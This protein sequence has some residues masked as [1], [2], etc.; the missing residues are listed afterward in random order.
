MRVRG[1]ASVP[2]FRCLAGDI[3]LRSTQIAPK[4]QGFNLQA[5]K[6]LD[7]SVV[8]VKS[9]VGGDYPKRRRTGDAAHRGL[10]VWCDGAK[11]DTVLA[12]SV[13]CR[14]NGWW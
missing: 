5:Q 11:N 9:T 12:E 4:T 2:G 1:K 8:K 10:E 7:G 14:S 13:C 3:L 6:L